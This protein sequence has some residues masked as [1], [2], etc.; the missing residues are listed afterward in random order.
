MDRTLIF[1]LAAA[2]PTGAAPDE[3]VFLPE[4]SHKITPQSH[5]KGIMVNVP[6]EKGA[7]IA[8]SLQR[9]L[10]KRLGENVKPWFD[11]EH[12]R[13]FPASGYPKSFRYEPGKGIMCSLEWSQSGR[14]AVEGRDVAYFSPEVF[15]GKD[16]IPNGLPDR[17]PVGGMVTEPAFR[18]IPRIAAADAGLDQLDPTET[19]S[20]F[21]IL[22]SIGLLTQTE[23]AR[24]DAESLA[25]SR[26]TAMRKDGDD[27]AE[28]KTKLT[29]AETERDGLKT[30]LEA[31]DAKVKATADKRADDLVKAAIEDGRIAAKDEEKQKLFREK[32]AAGDA[33][34]ETILGDLPKQHEGLE[35]PLV[36]G[37][38]GD[39]V[40]TQG[41]GH[42]IEK[43][44]RELV[45]AKSAK[46]F[47]DALLMAADADPKLYDDYLASLK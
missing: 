17:G 45:S 16:G 24:D 47:D 46:N 43:K 36:T 30:K 22:A 37:A 13:K 35:K 18:D 21:L 11:F 7:E 41:G 2:L 38:A 9:D 39:R 3:I 28:T 19:M 42:P 12:T 25:R 34:F 33:A 10:D 27:L 23:A 1:A 40:P 15:I 32:I 4:G 29:A 8:A 5:P 44:A 26:V 14:T 6:P 20:Q 31:S